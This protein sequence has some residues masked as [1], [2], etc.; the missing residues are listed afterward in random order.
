MGPSK[1]GVNSGQSHR[2]MES[3]DQVLDEYPFYSRVDIRDLGDKRLRSQIKA[4]NDWKA[5]KV[6]RLSLG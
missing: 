3:G 1:W 2:Q 4:V 5:I 6:V